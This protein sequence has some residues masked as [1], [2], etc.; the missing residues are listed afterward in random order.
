MSTPTHIEFPVQALDVSHG[1]EATPAPQPRSS[2]RHAA[3]KMRAHPST[4]ENPCQGVT[5]A[6]LVSLTGQE[7]LLERPSADADS[8]RHL[9]G[10]LRLGCAP[11]LTSAHPVTESI[12]DCGGDRVAEQL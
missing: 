4:D 3:E 1:H 8:D 6:R 5:L 11:N 2:T 7:S 9:S 10:I 12:C